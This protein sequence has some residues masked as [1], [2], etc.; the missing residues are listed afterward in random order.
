MY[1]YICVCV[2]LC[3]CL[4][5]WLWHWTR[6]SIWRCG[7]Q[8]HDDVT[9]WKHFP[10]YCPFVRGIHRSPVNSPHKDQWRGALVFSLICVW[11]NGWVHNRKAGDLRCY[12]AHFDVT[13][14]ELDLLIWCLFIYIGGIVFV[15]RLLHW[16][17]FTNTSY[18]TIYNMIY[19]CCVVVF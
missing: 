1:I 15:V 12:R 8:W 2:Y 5:L 9:K 4:R 11:I 19:K 16:F 6:F 7:H 18:V 14:M 17:S 3:M 13:V 10:R